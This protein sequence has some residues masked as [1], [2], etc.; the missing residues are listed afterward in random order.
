MV[1]ILSHAW[2]IFFKRLF[3]YYNILP[4]AIV[5]CDEFLIKL[6]KNTVLKY[7]CVPVR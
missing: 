3:L 6:G 5:L 4:T 2:Q 1:V 7:D